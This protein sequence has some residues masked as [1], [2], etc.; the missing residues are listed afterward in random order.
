MLKSTFNIYH[1]KDITHKG[2]KYKFKKPLRVKITN[3]ISFN[4]KQLHGEMHITDVDDGYT[5]I[6]PFN[7]PEKEIKDYIRTVFN[8]YLFKKDEELDEYTRKYK[9]DW[10]NLIQQ[11]KEKK[12][13]C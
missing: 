2:I 5:R 4:G 8:D 11:P 13:K 9:H 6:E 10:I 3:F 7:N 12:P 1:I